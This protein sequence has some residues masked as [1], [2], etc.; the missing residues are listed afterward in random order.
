MNNTNFKK[1]ELLAPAGNL[2][3]AVIALDSGADAVYIGLQKFNARERAENFSFSDA[4]KLINYAHKNN[5]KVYIAFNTLIKE[6]ELH[7]A[8]EI[9]VEINN[10]QPDAVIIQDLGIA[11]LIKTY[12]PKLQIH[13]STQMAIHNSAGINVARDMGISRVILERQVMHEELKEIMKKNNDMEIEVFV[14][15]ALCCSLSGQCLFSSWIGGRS[16]NRGKCTQPCRRRFYSENG[17]GFFFSTKDLASLEDLPKLIQ[18]GIAS[19]KIEG[20]LKKP[21]Y[22]KN[23]ISAFRLIIDATPENIKTAMKNAKEIMRRVA[24]RSLSGGFS[25]KQEMENL[26]EHKKMGVTGIYCGKIIK[27]TNSGFYVSVTKKIHIGDILRLQEYAGDNSSALAVSYISIKGKSVQKAVNGDECFIKCDRPAPQNAAVY[28][29]GESYTRLNARLNSL[30][31]QRK[32]FDLKINVS[33]SGFIV[34]TP[35][36]N[37]EK[38]LQIEKAN[39]F[40]LVNEKIIKAFSASGNS[41]FEADNIDVKITGDLFLPDSVLK[42][43]KKE[44]WIAFNEMYENSNSISQQEQALIDFE[45]DYKYKRKNA[46]T[47]LEHFPISS[48][49]KTECGRDALPIEYFHRGLRE[50]ILPSFCAE[51]KL[52]QLAKLI[53]QIKH[54]MPDITIRLTSIYQIDILKQLDL[55]HTD[56]IITYPCPVC[57]SFTI[58]ELQQLINTDNLNLIKIQAWVELEEKEIINLKQHSHLPLEIFSS[59]RVPLMSTRATIPVSGIIHDDRGAEYIIE[60]DEFSDITYIYSNKFLNIPRIQGTAAFATCKKRTSKK[61]SSSFNFKREF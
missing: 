58:D 38:S 59:G 43:V 21:D 18:L 13:A 48:L 37:W 34:K 10:L 19:F 36:G 4:S 26:I 56:I 40:P 7:D 30:S 57:N 50:I 8:L 2:Q 23:V 20:R 14:Q 53:K 17:N 44:F 32:K 42:K 49:N 29:T 61:L 27:T 12:F 60:K 41:A 5:K 52:K 25:S 46:Q 45:Q 33:N 6:S 39:K 54:Q 35:I 24:G 22:I 11:N 31:E 9:L 3:S 1:P 55:K 15:G 28:K 51:T 16:G 47:A